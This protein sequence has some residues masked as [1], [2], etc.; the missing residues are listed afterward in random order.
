MFG[1]EGTWILRRGREGC[2]MGCPGPSHHPL[3]SSHLPI[4]VETLWLTVS[5]LNRASFLL[6]DSPGTWQSLPVSI[7]I[8]EGKKSVN[9][10]K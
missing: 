3:G 1:L 9:P 2:S 7:Y 10:K 4:Q 8:L 6:G 5:P